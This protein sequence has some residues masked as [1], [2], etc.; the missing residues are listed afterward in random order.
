MTKL[1]WLKY[2]CN[3]LQLYVTMV[4]G[5]LSRPVVLKLSDTHI[6]FYN[7]LPP[8]VFYIKYIRKPNL[9]GHQTIQTELCDTSFE[10]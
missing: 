10:L 2:S 4:A 5:T 6:W 1:L 8:F 7:L 3:I 9:I